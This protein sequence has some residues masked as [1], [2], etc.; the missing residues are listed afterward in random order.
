MLREGNTLTMQIN[1]SKVEN[2]VKLF[3]QLARLKTLLKELIIRFCKF[4]T[5]TMVE[6]KKKYPSAIYPTWHLS[7][8]YEYESKITLGS[9][10]HFLRFTPY[11]DKDMKH[12]VHKVYDKNAVFGVFDVIPK[13]KLLDLFLCSEQSMAALP[14]YKSW[15][16]KIN[17]LSILNSRIWSIVRILYRIMDKLPTHIDGVQFDDMIYLRTDMIYA[18]TEIL[19]TST[20]SIIPIEE[21][22]KYVKIDIKFNKAETTRC[23]LHDIVS[24]RIKPKATRKKKTDDNKA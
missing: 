4:S 22:N 11:K 1:K 6:T 13:S 9:K 7:E 15:K 24:R 17:Q 18:R 12:I 10:S 23:G 8:S 3:R 2:I 20:K 19:I 14:V 21:L 5:T 16:H